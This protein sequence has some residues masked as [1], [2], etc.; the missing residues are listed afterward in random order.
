M[1]LNTQKTIATLLNFK[2]ILATSMAA[3]TLLSSNVGAAPTDQN[4]KTA[5]GKNNG[6][7]VTQKKNS[8]SATT[9]LTILEVL[10]VGSCAGFAAVSMKK[11]KN[12]KN[13]LH[14]ANAQF[15][16][17]A[18]Q[19]NAQI[20][21]LE[22]DID[23]LTRE[24]D[25]ALEQRATDFQEFNAACDD[26]THPTAVADCLLPISNYNKLYRQEREPV[27]VNWLRDNYAVISQLRDR[28]GKEVLDNVLCNLIVLYTTSPRA[29]DATTEKIR[30]AVASL[31][32]LGSNRECLVSLY[33]STCASD[34]WYSPVF[35]ES[36]P[37]SINIRAIALQQSCG[38]SA[39][40]SDDSRSVGLRD[41]DWD[42]LLARSRRNRK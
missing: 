31:D 32:E 20:A 1:K 38:D 15:S 6:T 36:T 13:Q 16:T 37:L 30:S 23:R 4:V 29:D 22:A 18:R 11:C 27:V 33:D 8:N 24:R 19:K 25:D 21:A 9:M 42:A 26:L 10:L 28:Y 7:A 34:L 2:K 17:R 5:N 3:I 40:P 14:D 35:D 41:T 12:Y 39:L